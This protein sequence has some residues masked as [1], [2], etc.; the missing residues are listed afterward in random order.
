[1]E[2]LKILL[3]ASIISIIPGQIIRLP[4]FLEYGAVNLTDLSVFAADIF[5]LIYLMFFKKSLNLSKKVFPIFFIFVIWTLATNI[6]SLTLFNIQQILISSFFLLRFL[7]YFFISQLILNVVE[8]DKITN[9]LNLIVF[10]AFI[11][12]LVGF[13]QLLTFPDLTS[14]TAYGWDPHQRRI[15]S[16]LL[17]PNFTGFIFV[18]T[19]AISTTLLLFLK[20]QVGK[21]SKRINFVYSK[22]NFVYLLV[23][24]FSIIG[25]VLTFSR[26]SYLALI[27]PILIIGLV[28]SPKMLFLTTSFLLLSF[29]TIPQVKNRVI[30]AVTLDDTSQARIISWKNA[31][32]IFKN[33]PLFG[34]GFNNYRY[35]Q[36]KY[37][38]YDDPNQVELHSSSGSDS[39]ILL[40]AATTG[41]IGLFLFLTLL[42]TLLTTAIKKSSKEP[43]KLI[44]LSVL[45]SL[46]IHSQFVNSF[47]FPQISVLF[48]FI[49]GLSQINDI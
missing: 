49:F 32:S 22:K 25:V 16:T 9:W 6:F 38:L 2:I 20:K 8:K 33:Q 15:V 39:S 29:F 14:L 46:I 31:V 30:G 45:V 43:V 21:L 36:E 7:S 35:A 11:F 40:V 24:L 10:S 12:I 18:V 19:F 48:W 42:G 28:K 23:S 41:L 1:M 17:D 34:V 5:G 13:I 3:I 26:S 27:A 37:Q 47:F 4:F 44:F